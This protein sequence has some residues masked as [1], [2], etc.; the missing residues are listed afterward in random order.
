MAPKP[1]A[2]RQKIKNLPQKVRDAY[3]SVDVD[4]VIEKIGQEHNL[5]ID[6]IGELAAETGRVMLGTT[7]PSEYVTNLKD[8]LDVD[9]EKARA[10]A[11]DV[12]ERVFKSIREELKSIHIKEGG[13][14][15]TEEE[16][17]TR[18]EE[19]VEKGSKNIPPRPESKDETTRKTQ[20]AQQHTQTTMEHDDSSTA[21]KKED[22]GQK[23]DILE[24]DKLLRDVETAAQT[25]DGETQEN[26][27]KSEERR[28]VKN[29][30][31]SEAEI[32]TPHYGAESTENGE[33]ET[34]H[35]EQKE[36]ETDI[37]RDKMEGNFTIP[38]SERTER[39]GAP[40]PP[41][42]KSKNI[43]YNEHDPYREPI[44]E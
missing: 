19:G 30:Q 28:E 27:K 25:P 3:F 14:R 4:D 8:T 42:Q 2:L 15:K 22:E 32:S 11:E 26:N 7:H 38:R 21:E 35:A 36:T 17:T 34:P 5:H 16:K 43:Q 29:Q 10:I 12:N 41:D 31:S 39:E 37:S 33:Q 24:R 9:S 13:G 44:D 6:K 23:E 18:Q 20:Q 1:E 40:I